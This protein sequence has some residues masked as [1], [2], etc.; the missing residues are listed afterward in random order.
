MQTFR[1][2][3]TGRKVELSNQYGHAWLNGANE[4]VMSDDPKFNPNAQLS[5][6]WNQLQPVP[7][8]LE[9]RPC[10]NRRAPEY[11]P[12][13]VLAVSIQVDREAFKVCE[14]AMTQRPLMRRT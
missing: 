9:H 1:D 10:S 11:I 12:N 2:P 3:T 4:Y 8:L 13:R 5:G 7:P 6:S 14:R